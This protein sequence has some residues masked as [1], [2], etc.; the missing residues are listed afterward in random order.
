M[1]TR[2]STIP[3]PLFDSKDLCR[4]CH[5]RCMNFKLAVLGSFHGHLADFPK[6]RPRMRVNQFPS[7]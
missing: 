6:I 3:V 5:L 1:G 4:I 2:K 7:T